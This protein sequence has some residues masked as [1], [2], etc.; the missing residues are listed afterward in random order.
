MNYI[1]QP[2]R[3]LYSFKGKDYIYG[4]G[5]LADCGRVTASLGSKVAIVADQFPG[6]EAFVQTIRE[7]LRAAGVDVTAII[8][9]AKPNAPREDVFRIRDGVRAVQP[10]VVLSFGGGSTTDATKAAAVLCVLGGGVDEYFGTGLV[11]Q[12]LREAGK[13]LT[14]Q[15]AIQTNASSAA[16]LTKYSN[17]TEVKS[18]QKKLIVDDAI[19]P[20]RAVFD[21]SVTYAAP[22]SLAA[23]GALDGVSHCLEVLYS[24][25]G[26]PNY[27]LVEQVAT[28]GIGIIINYLERAITRPGDQEAR[29]ALCLATDLGGYAIMLGGTNGAHLNSFSFV[30][31]LSHGRA[32]GIMNPYYT[33]FFAPA[34]ERPLKA[35]GKIYRDAGLVKSDTDRLSG[36]DLG[37]ALAEGM[38]ELARRIGFPIR[39]RDVPGFGAGH[40]SRALSAAKDPQ[41]RSKLENMPVPLTPEM[42]DEYMGSVLQAARDGNLSLI[43]NVGDG[44]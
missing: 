36:R 26:K 23:D 20:A 29:N 4:Q 40:I 17:I 8:G 3:L 21:Y 19:V 30:D 16:H 39:L 2:R 5:V 14:S 24:A 22:V 35:V 31:I 12:A 38:F 1:D 28:T 9:G 34:V 33:V 25:V 27:D 13:K 37:V 18:G 6:A 10:D 7:S 42:V 32:C 11:T 43:K 44:K 41:L 15:V